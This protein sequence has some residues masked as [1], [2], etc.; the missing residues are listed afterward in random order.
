M[1][2]LKFFV[3]FLFVS[4]RSRFCFNLGELERV[5]AE[6]MQS[7][8]ASIYV[9]RFISIYLEY[10]QCALCLL[11]GFLSLDGDSL[12][13]RIAQMNSRIMN[14][15]EEERDFKDSVKFC[16]D[17]DFV[18][19]RNVEDFIKIIRL[20]DFKCVKP[21]LPE[22][23]IELRQLVYIVPFLSYKSAVL[24]EFLLRIQAR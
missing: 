15:G 22:G 23:E 24:S 18:L 3:L 1:K 21:E 7:K 14:L 5:T 9:E 16:E 2:C 19:D 20:N 6:L 13:S 4:V 17:T 8:E 11:N 12:R 10:C